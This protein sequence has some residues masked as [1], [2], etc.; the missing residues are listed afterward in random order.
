MIYIV[1]FP[2]QGRVRSWFAFDTDDF[3]RKVYASDE[4]DEW[5]IF[6]IVTVR[7]LLEGVGETPESATANPKFPAIYGMGKQHGW[8]TP[9]YRADYLLG[10]GNFQPEPIREAE[11]C[12]AALARRVKLCRV[13]WSDSEATAALEGEPLFENKDGYWGR[14]ALREQLVA[15]EVIEG[16]LG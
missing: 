11:A 7:E 10:A 12:A 4:L 9:L 13:Y 1:E 16:P 15:L 8:D 5:E 6:D 3:A 2:D 14:E